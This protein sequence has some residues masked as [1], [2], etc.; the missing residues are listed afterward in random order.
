LRTNRQTRNAIAEEE[1]AILEYEVLIKT[2]SESFLNL[3]SFQVQFKKKSIFSLAA[4]FH[5]SSIC[6][7]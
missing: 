3:L 4:A 5:S 2:E 7:S 6:I 1:E